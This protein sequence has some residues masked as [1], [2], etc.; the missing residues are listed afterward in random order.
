MRLHI[1]DRTLHS[2]IRKASPQPVILWALVIH[3][4]LPLNTAAVRPGL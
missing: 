2:L 3:P 1:S 4:K